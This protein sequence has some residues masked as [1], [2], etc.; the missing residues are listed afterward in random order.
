MVV[1]VRAVVRVA[2]VMVVGVLYLSV[3]IV[4]G[5]VVVL[6]L[7]GYGGGDVNGWL[8]AVMLT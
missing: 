3:S 4:V 1:V 6:V 2:N 5:M 8:L 7:V